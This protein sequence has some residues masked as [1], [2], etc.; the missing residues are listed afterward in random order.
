LLTRANACSEISN[1]SCGRKATLLQIEEVNAPGVGI[2]VLSQAE[3]ETV[4]GSNIRTHAHRHATL[5]D[6]IQTG[7]LDVG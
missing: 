4:A 7:D 2:A 5:E 1:G 3:Q 6:F